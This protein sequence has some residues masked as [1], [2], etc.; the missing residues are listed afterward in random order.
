MLI[1]D[2]ENRL[3]GRDVLE[4]EYFSNI[5]WADFRAMRVTPPFIPSAK[6]TVGDTSNFGSEYTGKP[7]RFSVMHM[8]EDMAK[9]SDAFLKGFSYYPTSYY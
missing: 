9:E 8:D 3:C 2:P 6:K 4:H 7:V 1:K 5:R